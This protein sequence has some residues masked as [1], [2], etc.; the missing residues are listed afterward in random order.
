MQF[1]RLCV[2]PKNPLLLGDQNYKLSVIHGKRWFHEKQYEVGKSWFDLLPLDSDICF[3]HSTETEP[4]I[5]FH[6]NQPNWNYWVEKS[7]M[8]LTA[9]LPPLDAIFIA[10]I[11][12]TLK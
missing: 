7:E 11:G 2:S 8:Q 12:S 10:S 9:A 3:L 6:L 1:D 5:C 4:F